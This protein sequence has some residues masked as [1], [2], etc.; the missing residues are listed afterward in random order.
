MKYVFLNLLFPCLLTAHIGTSAIS[1]KSA[2]YDGRA[3]MLQ[4][5]VEVMHSLGKMES[6]SARL[7]KEDPEG[8]F[9]AIHLKDHVL[10]S[11]NGKGE[12]ACEEAD[13]DF[14]GMKGC[15]LSTVGNQ[16]EFSHIGGD[17][18]SIQ[19][20]KADIEFEEDL[21]GL[22]VVKVEALDKVKVLYRN[23]FAL[24][25][26][27]A[28]YSNGNTPSVTASPHCILTHND[29]QVEASKVEL[30]PE[31]S[32][33]VLSSPKGKL[34]P[35][36]FSSIEGVTFSCKRLIWEHAPQL[37][38][39]KGE[40]LVED[41]TIGKIRCDDE[42]ELH[43]K[44]KEGRWILSTITAKGKTTLNYQ[45]Q[46]G[47]EH[48]LVCYGKMHLDQESLTLTLDSPQ[49]KPLEYFH[50]QLKLSAQHAE[51]H[52]SDETEKVRPYCLQLKKDVHLMSYE[53]SSRC[54]IADEFTY[55]PDQGKMILSAK[56]NGHVLFWDQ[57]EDLSISAREVHLKRSEK[58]DQIKGVGD[59]RFAFSGTENELLKKVFPFYKP[60]KSK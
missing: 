56:E 46:K 47:I 11:L 22:K 16:V 28:T 26:D 15:L 1:S 18:L 38:T 2:S 40:V 17:P 7:E 32:K 33:V 43:Q 24:N 41:E 49:E 12:I 35:S 58:G 39:L 19:T 44:E 45:L 3:L 60:R 4:G 27:R 6:N 8:P 48:A 57:N 55:Y 59:V 50:D 20:S 5:A 31:D 37:L 29:D 14:V 36:A 42:I 13:F 9:S 54:A 21:D 52:Y 53:D 10:I 34:H 51:L 23:G 25:A 30:F